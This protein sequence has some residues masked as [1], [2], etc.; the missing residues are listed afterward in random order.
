MIYTFE[1][2][3]LDM[4]VYELRYAGM[5]CKLEP[6]A[7]NVLV[8]L[9]QHRDRVVTKEELLEHLWP[10]RCVGEA[11]LSQRLMEARKAIGDDGRTQR[12]LKTIRGRGYRFM[13]AVESHD[14]PR[15][16]EVPS[17]LASTA[18]ELLEAPSN[19]P[20]TP[21]STAEEA[22]RCCLM[23]HQA[24]MPE[25]Q[26]CTGCGTRL[27]D[28]CAHCSQVVQ[29]QTTFGPACGPLSPE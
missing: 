10:D 19:Q 27:V 11:T 8:Y 7:F 14:G 13:A 1:D 5:P 3:E 18:A 22:A 15:S 23:G 17:C 20:A 6:Q 24:R 25:A 26:L 4:W 16:A 2:Y 12:V 21:P 29:M 9:L 28:T